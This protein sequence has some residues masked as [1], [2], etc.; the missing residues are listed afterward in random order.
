V[1]R[2]SNGT[3]VDFVEGGNYVDAS[4]AQLAH[5]LRIVDGGAE[6]GDR[7]KFARRQLHHL[8]GAANAHAESEFLR[9]DDLHVP[10]LP[11][12]SGRCQPPV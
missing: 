4:V 8:H 1:S 2:D 12:E 10:N 11:C 9:L 7:S 6:T 3:G 5:H